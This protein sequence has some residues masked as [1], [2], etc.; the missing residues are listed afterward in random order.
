[1]TSSDRQLRRGLV[2]GCGGTLGAAWTVA[3][4]ASVRDALDW[5]PRE[6]EV[7]VGT[8]A[9]AELVTMLG[10]GVGVDELLAMQLGEQ[11]TDP[12]LRTHLADAPGRFPPLPRFGLGSPRLARAGLRREVAPVTALSGLL[13]PGGGDAGW[14]HQLA[15]GMAPGRM[16]VSHPA[17][18]LVAMDYDSGERVAFGSPGAPEA[19]LS[20]ALRASWAIP[21]WFPPVR[22]GDRR[23]VDGGA[24][25][26]ASADLVASLHLDE[27][28]VLAPMASTGRVPGRGAAR[29]ERLVLRGWMSAGLDAEVAAVEAAG[30]RV[31][32]LDATAEDLAVMGPNFMDDRRRLATLES[33]LRTTRAALAHRLATGDVR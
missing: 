21:G 8:S 10:G 28:V 14:L 32:R 33:S 5:D 17:T 25:S 16:W 7:L 19:T 15:L 22:V 4:L 13:P 27:L 6:A 11:V 3:A 29:A 26:T 12:A 1:M 20:Q 24:A 23:F 2:I 9:G 18:W 31:I 30:T